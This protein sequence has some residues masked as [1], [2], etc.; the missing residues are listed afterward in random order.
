MD[1]GTIHYRSSPDT[2]R[3]TCAK[4]SL[5]WV[6]SSRANLRLTW[7]YNHRTVTKKTKYHDRQLNNAQH[8]LTTHNGVDYSW[9]KSA[10]FDRRKLTFR[11][12]SA[13]YENACGMWDL[14]HKNPKK[15]A[16]PEIGRIAFFLRKF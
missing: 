10:L 9:K 8:L 15:K 13:V 1:G 11:P 12:P 5:D 14:I 7:Y 3:R 4:L 16:H 6:L 2:I